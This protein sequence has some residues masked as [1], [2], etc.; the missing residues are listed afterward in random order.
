MSAEGGK[1]REVVTW[2]GRLRR[3]ASLLEG[4]L[5]PSQH[6]KLSGG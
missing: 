5:A 6:C 3:P 1:G 4:A 2:S